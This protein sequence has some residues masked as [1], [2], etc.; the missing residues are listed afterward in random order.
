V[1]Q[2]EVWVGG[3]SWVDRDAVID[4]ESDNSSANLRN[5]GDTFMTDYRGGIITLPSQDL[6]IGSADTHFFWR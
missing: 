3:V 4:V 2:Q 1:P 6:Y 5:T